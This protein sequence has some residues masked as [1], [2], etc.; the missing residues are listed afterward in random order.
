MNQSEYE[1][2]TCRRRQARENACDEVTIGF[3]SDWLG[4]L[5]ESVVMQTQSNCE[6]TLDTQLKP[7][8]CSLKSG[9]I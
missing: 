5:R 4:N 6:I 8:L 3:T 2:N 7:A 1:A 9:W